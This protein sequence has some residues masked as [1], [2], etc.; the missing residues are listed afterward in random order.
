MTLQEAKLLAH[1]FRVL[2]VE[3]TRVRVGPREYA[4]HVFVDGARVVYHE[5]EDAVRYAIKLAG[6]G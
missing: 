1:T 2:G 6:G 5:S 3:V 4:L